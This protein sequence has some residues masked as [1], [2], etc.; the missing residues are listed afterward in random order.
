M[1]NLVRK[2]ANSWLIKTLL[3]LL[4]VAFVGTIF[5]SWG[6]G[7]RYDGRSGVL[8][9]VN[10]IN[11][12]L[13]E[14]DQSFNNLVNFYRDQF[15]NQFSEEMIEK[16]DL[17]NSALE[18]L[19]TKKL[20]LLEAEKQNI[21]VSDEELADE[22]KTNPNF[23]KDDKFS[24]SLY[25]AFLS[26]NRMSARDFET[27]QREFLLMNK[28]ETFIKGNIHV[29]DSEV[30]EELKKSNHKVKIAYTQF[31]KDYFQSQVEPTGEQLEKYFEAHKKDFETPAKIKVQFAKLVPKDV[32]G[33]IKIYDEDISDYYKRNEVKY[34]IKKQYK[35][36]H[37]LFNL[38]PQALPNASTEEKEKALN[39]AEEKAKSQALEILKKLRE[40]ADFAE[41]AKEH[42][43]DKS[44]GAN[45]GELGQFSKGTMVPEFE[46][47]L[48]KLKPG[49]ISEPV[50]TMFGFHLIKLTD[51]KEG[52]ER[53]LEEVKEEITE[54]LKN[55]KAVQRI[56][57]IAKKIFSTS[58][59]NND[60]EST[61]KSYPATIHT[62][63][64]ISSTN[65]D[66]PEVGVVPEFFNTAFTLK[67]NVVSAPVNTAEAS[68]IL[69]VIDRKLPTIPELDAVKDRVKEAY[70]EKKH[71]EVTEAKFKILAD[72]LA[73]D[74]DLEKLAK[75]NSLQVDESPYF[76]INDS[77]PGIGNVQS[78][79]NALFKLKKG[80]TTKGETR[81]AYV[82]AKLMDM[83]EADA[84]NEDQK[85]EIY[86]RLKEEKGNAVFKEWMEQA[87]AEADILIDK[88]LL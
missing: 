6:M 32:L 61:V 71:F 65:H 28:V 21:Q 42:S 43:F 36:S 54:T 73:K 64:F 4:V 7:G 66:V 77:I 38:E 3:W 41:M 81:Q 82:L 48:D 60:L 59:P 30:Q 33:E 47:A 85:K 55:M 19:I 18:A 68:F 50:Q 52:R 79:K 80:E 53:P 58:Q 51:V 34:L 31:S 74:P 45:G 17:K 37:I 56:R 27:N 12:N 9:T 23:Q 72:Q 84:S 15:Q 20:L 76:S 13:N 63:E 78:F 57:R 26:Y 88:T 75:E 24:R 39:E 11:I 44:S 5:Y 14:Y 8:G 83:E 67:E 70:M 29:S 69:K 35:A 1:L 49:E 10:G 40:G 86:D 87:K 46:E 25:E 2:H 62:T 16:L 22:I